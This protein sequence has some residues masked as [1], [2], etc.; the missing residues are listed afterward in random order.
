MI[1]VGVVAAIRA[2]GARGETCSAMRW[3]QSNAL[4]YKF[5]HVHPLHIL[6][7]QHRD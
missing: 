7:P 1:N 5:H 2:V 3:T 4:H 6:L